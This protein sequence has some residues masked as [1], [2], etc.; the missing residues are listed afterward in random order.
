VVGERA[1]TRSLSALFAPPTGAG[2]L[3]IGDDG[4]VLVNRGR[5]T[6]A[7]CDPVVEGVHFTAATPLALVGRKVVNRNLADLAA[8]GATFDYA[9]VAIQWPR[10]RA[11]RGVHA[12]LRGIRDAVESRGGRVVGGD[13]GSTSG[14]LTVTVTALGHLRHRA[15]RR[16]GARAGDA[17]HVSAPLGGSILGGH[18]RFAPPLELGQRLAAGR[19]VSAAMDIS[20]GLALDLATL[21]E[22][23]AT[24]AGVALGAELDAA[25]IPIA[26]AARRLAVRTG[27]SPL[28][29]ALG[30]GED[31]ALLFTVRPKVVWSTRGLPAV[32]RCPIGRVVRGAGLTLVGTD[33]A[34]TTLAVTGYEHGLGR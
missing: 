24:R 26:A 25:A 10:A 33:G 19:A 32:A 14:P 27:R 18:L 23:S 9:L 6:V 34:R 21:L 5:H 20:D 4:A 30:D 17:I 28:Q 7:V 2:A 13:T 1:L 29:H 16:D 15:L 31:H 12:L 3:G 22:A 11:A 8:M